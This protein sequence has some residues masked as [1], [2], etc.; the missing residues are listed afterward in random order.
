[1]FRLPYFTS[2]LFHPDFARPLFIAVILLG[3]IG[4][5]QQR[6][7]V[8]FPLFRFHPCQRICHT[9]YIGRNIRVLGHLFPRIF[10][11]RNTVVLGL[12]D[13]SLCV[14]FLLSLPVLNGL[15]E[16][17]LLIILTSGHRQFGR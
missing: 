10:H 5:F 17:A 14:K 4:T 9:E 16:I 12:N 13:S 8:I 7:G 1:M 6:Y 11:R 3:F 2:Q 15:P